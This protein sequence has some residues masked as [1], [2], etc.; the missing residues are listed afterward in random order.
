M[1]RDVRSL[2][3]DITCFFSSIVTV[4]RLFNV[5]VGVLAYGVFTSGR[6]E[7]VI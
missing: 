3:G 7:A 1:V 2:G 6:G 5:F 4:R